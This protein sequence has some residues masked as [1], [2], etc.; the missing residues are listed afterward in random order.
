MI[1]SNRKAGSFRRW[2][3]STVTALAFVLSVAHAAEYSAGEAM[4]SVTGT[5]TL[6]TAVRTEAR[7][8]ALLPNAN[9]SQIGIAGLAPGGRNQDDGNLNFA[10]GDAVA[11]VIKG[12]V[13]FGARRENLGLFARVKYWHDFILADRGM[14][15]GNYPNGYAAGQPLG[16]SGFPTRA[17]F[18]GVVAEDAYVQGSFQPWD[19]PLQLKLG[20]QTLPWGSG[21]SIGGGVG[22]INPSDGPASRRPGALA[23]E[24]SIAFSAAYARFE[25]APNATAELFAQFGFEPSV[26]V[27]CGTFYAITDYMAP[28]CDRIWV[29]GANDRSATGFRT[30]AAT[31]E[32]A[33]SGQYGLAFSYRVEPLATTFGVTSAQYHSRMPFGSMVK[34]ATPL[35]TQYF[36]EYP[37]RIRLF[38]LQFTTQLQNTTIQ[39]ALTYRPNQPVQL[40]GTDL[41]LAFATANPALLRADAAATATGAAYR[42]YDQLK[43]TQLQFA[44]S[45]QLDRTLGARSAT[46]GAEVGMKLVNDL[47]DAGRRRYGRL[48]VFGAGPIPGAACSGSAD[49]CT[50]NGYVSASSWGYRLRVQLSY[51][52]LIAGVD[53]KPG[54]ALGH[55][56]RG[57]SADGVFIE[58]RKLAVLSLRADLGKRYY[59]ELAWQGA[60]GGGYDNVRDRDTA[61]L[62]IGLRF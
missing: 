49:V 24:R 55:D 38:A 32:V 44:V 25:V 12:Y 10:K 30:R 35:S 29:S 22:D 41:L 40:N 27:P 59:S 5:L 13:D 15:W 50:S 48:D 23:E 11:T 43:T 26:V 19:K 61:S 42:G 2:F 9:S 53:L 8:A 6:G 56:V 60:W 62:V 36:T 20:R 31:P 57:W 58:G 45:R 17:R 51:P 46:L 52:G 1:N 4:L 7:D 33:D 54:L 3:A 28:G 21:F 16:E 37:E 47:P 39:G 18:S 34:G 14:P